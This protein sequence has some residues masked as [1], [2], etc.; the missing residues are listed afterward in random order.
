MTDATGDEAAAPRTGSGMM[1][2]LGENLR[3]LSALLI[4]AVYLV[5]LV[6]L[7]TKLAWL[8]PP[9]GEV[10]FSEDVWEQMIYLLAALGTLATSAAGVLLGVQIQQSSVRNANQR[11]AEAEAEAAE[12]TVRL[13]AKDAIL[14]DMLAT[15]T[16]VSTQS[17]SG[18]D[19]RATLRAA[20]EI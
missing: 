18:A 11:A 12:K 19:M 10:G 17:L 1:G 16:E 8:F 4:V 15:G 2:A 6:W 13:Q 20:I 3:M 9:E 14:V 5:L 7:I